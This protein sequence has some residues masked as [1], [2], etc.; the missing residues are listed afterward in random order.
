MDESGKG[1]APAAPSPPS[2][3]ALDPAIEALNLQDTAKKAAYILK[4]AHPHVVFTSGRRDKAGQASAM[5]SNVVHNRKWIVQ[6]YVPSV[7]RDRC[8]QCVDQNPSK[9]TTS[10]IA[11]LLLEVLEN[12][13]DDVLS[14]LSKHLSGDAFDVEPVTQDAE[15]VKQTIRS[16]PGLSKFLD[17]EGGL[18]RWHAQF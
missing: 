15:A 1:V 13:A 11:A 7:A 3:F 18:V 14:H 6:T 9:T 5:A 12:L 4:K 17:H 10:S 16:L 8:Q 2:G